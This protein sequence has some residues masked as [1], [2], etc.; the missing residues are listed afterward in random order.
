MQ[1][2]FN[3]KILLIDNKF[4]KEIFKKNSKY[5][6]CLHENEKSNTQENIVFTEV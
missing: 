4:I 6:I 1:V 2:K 3:K 5:R